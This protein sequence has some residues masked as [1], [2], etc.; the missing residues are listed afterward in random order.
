MGSKSPSHRTDPG[1]E[2]VVRIVILGHGWI[3]LSNEPA[4]LAQYIRRKREFLWWTAVK[5]E[6]LRCLS[7]AANVLSELFVGTSWRS[8]KKNPR[9]SVGRSGYTH[10][11]S[12]SCFPTRPCVRVRVCLRVHPPYTHGEYIYTKVHKQNVP[13]FV[14]GKLVKS[15]PVVIWLNSHRAS[16]HVWP[17]FTPLIQLNITNPHNLSMYVT[18][19]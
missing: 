8:G 18:Y 7:N 19:A 15:D 14:Y 12:C 17:N 5:C 1:S 16:D 4:S 2:N 11:L 10:P 6:S 3:K 9:Y 13:M